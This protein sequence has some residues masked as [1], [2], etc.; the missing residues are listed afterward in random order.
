MRWPWRRRKWPTEAEIRVEQE[1]AVAHVEAMLEAGEPIIHV[2]GRAITREAAWAATQAIRK[3]WELGGRYEGQ[4]A[5]GN[6]AWVAHVEMPGAPPQ[7]YFLGT[8]PG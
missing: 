6:G 1:A 5:L 3:A 8:F 4:E 2:Y 7:T